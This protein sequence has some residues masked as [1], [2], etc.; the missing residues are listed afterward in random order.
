MLRRATASAVRASRHRQF[1]PTAHPVFLQSRTET[2]NAT[3]SE[4]KS[5]S[6]SPSTLT[7]VS[8]NQKPARAYDKSF[9]DEKLPPAPVPLAV[10]AAYHAPL[11]VPATHNVPSCDLQIRS[12]TLKN[13]EFFA[14]FAVRAAYYLQLPAFGPIPL[15]RRTERWTVPKSNFVHKKS[16]QNFE[17]VT[18]KRLVQIKDGHPDVVQVWLAFL[19]KHEYHG[20]GMK[21]NVY[22]F[23]K[24]GAGSNMSKRMAEIKMAA[25]E[26]T[27]DH[28]QQLSAMRRAFNQSHNNVPDPRKGKKIESKGPSPPLSKEDIMAQT[29]KAFRKVFID[30]HTLAKAIKLCKTKQK[31]D[32]NIRMKPIKQKLHNLNVTLDASWGVLN[33]I[34]AEIKPDVEQI[35]ALKA[36]NKDEIPTRL[37]KEQIDPTRPWSAQVKFDAMLKQ[38]KRNLDVVRQNARLIVTYLE[39]SYGKNWRY[40]SG[41]PKDGH[42]KVLGFVKRLEAMEKAVKSAAYDVSLEPWTMEER[43]TLLQNEAARKKESRRIVLAEERAT[44]EAAMEARMAEKARVAEE[45]RIAEAR[46]AEAKAAEETKAAEAR[47]TETRIVEED[48]IAEQVKKAEEARAA[49]ARAAEERRVAA[50]AKAAEVQAQET[51]PATEETAETSEAHSSFRETEERHT[52]PD[53][54]AAEAQEK[55]LKSGPLFGADT[56]PP[57]EPTLSEDAVAA[58][59]ANVDLKEPE[60]LDFRPAKEIQ[61][62]TENEPPIPR[63]TESEADVA[64]DSELVPP[65]TQEAAKDDFRNA[66][67]IQIDEA[68]KKKDE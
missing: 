15:P 48:R 35:E 22:A 11:K 50:E 5:P 16:Q 12:F 44:R 67:E 19:R 32:K 66:K 45:A 54:E 47:A 40:T 43:K 3:P 57:P 53:K 52:L 62:T 51:S 7:S 42:E 61:I 29:E 65:P 23:E 17:R 64:A 68:M 10:R 34:T 4:S 60:P 21:A 30:S 6:K 31:Q 49:D 37:S 58:D 28:N 14:D 33:R 27:A 8:I 20:I 18:Y 25:Y 2:T 1:K 39:R 24:M 36:L 63:P 26:G 41:V 46:A 38:A 55:P 9:P 56:A 13:V 59:K